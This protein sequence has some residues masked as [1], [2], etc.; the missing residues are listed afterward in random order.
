M[1]DIMGRLT[2]ME[3]MFTAN[4]C[5]EPDKSGTYRINFGAEHLDANADTCVD[6]RAE[7]QRLR[8]AL[9]A[10]IPASQSLALAVRQADPSILRPGAFVIA[11]AI[12][13]VL[14]HKSNAD[15]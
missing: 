8:A 1:N 6:A 7:I 12:R 13:E 9:A 10:R 3:R 2:E 15:S 5:E 4:R 14:M 11:R